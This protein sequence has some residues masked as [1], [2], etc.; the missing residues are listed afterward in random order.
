MNKKSSKFLLLE[1]ERDFLFE[2]LY[3]HANTVACYENKHNAH[4]YIVK[5]PLT[6]SF[7]YTKNSKLMSIEICV[8][9]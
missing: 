9:I 2:I 8:L 4:T 5:G 1:R 3:S 6:R 7:I